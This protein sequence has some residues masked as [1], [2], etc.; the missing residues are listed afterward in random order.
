MTDSTG[1]GV[2]ASLFT[3]HLDE[4]EELQ[5]GASSF[6]ETPV[7]A[8]DEMTGEPSLEWRRQLLEEA[9]TRI[10]QAKTRPLD[11]AKVYEA[12]TLLFDA[13]HGQFAR[14]KT[15]VAGYLV[16]EFV[17]GGEHE[18]G[19]DPSPATAGGRRGE[20]GDRARGGKSRNVKAKTG[21]SAKR[22]DIDDINRYIRDNYKA[23][24][25][26]EL[27]RRTGLSEHTIRRKL[28]EWG[29]KREKA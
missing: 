27:A 29:L 12:G 24:S 14:V 3:R 4:L 2:A 9:Q 25:N 23:H 11:P 5:S 26:R 10:K 13:E 6:E 21:S 17:R 16:V 22:A 20:G 15:S 19:H 18:Y 1:N 7:Y 8:D 28:G